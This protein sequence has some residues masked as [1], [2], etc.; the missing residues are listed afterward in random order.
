[1]VRKKIR[2]V[3]LLELLTVVLII[4]ILVALT[5]PRFS[6]MR[7]RALDKEAKANL[8]LIQAAEKIYRMEALIYYPTGENAD[9]AGINTNL[10]LDLSTD[11]DANWN[12]SI[13]DTGGGN[14]FDA[15]AA[16]N[17]PPSGWNREYSLDRNDSEACCTAIGGSGSQ[18]LSQ[19]EC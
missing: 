5:I 19:D 18:C 15:V 12:Y 17:N 14:N 2:S 7:E 13:D 16:R 1:M 11:A 6:A 3:T 9:T 8:K 4:G 10:R